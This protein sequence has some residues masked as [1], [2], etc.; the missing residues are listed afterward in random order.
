[1]LEFLIVLACRCSNRVLTAVRR[2]SRRE[3]PQSRTRSREAAADTGWLFWDPRNPDRLAEVGK[4]R[5]D[6]CLSAPVQP[7][8]CEPEGTDDAKDRREH[9]VA[10]AG[11]EERGSSGQQDDADDARDQRCFRLIATCCHNFR[12]LQT[13][14]GE[15]AVRLHVSWRS[16]GERSPRIRSRHRRPW[17]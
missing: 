2:A 11:G 3:H 9:L 17:R 8:A 16:V 6:L 12:S 15:G 7:G 4:Q 1:V 10:F 14:A 5:G 13:M